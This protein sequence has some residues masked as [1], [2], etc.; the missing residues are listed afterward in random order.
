MTPNPLPSA[1]Q[2]AQKAHLGACFSSGLDSITSRDPSQPLQFCGSVM[3]VGWWE[4]L[5]RTEAVAAGQG[6]PPGFLV[7][8]GPCSCC[9]GGSWLHTAC[10]MPQVLVSWGRT[11]LLQ[12]MCRRAHYCILRSSSC[13]WFSLP[14]MSKLCSFSLIFYLTVCHRVGHKW[15]YLNS[16]LS[17]RWGSG[18]ESTGIN[19]HLQPKD[20]GL[21]LCCPVCV[22]AKMLLQNVLLIEAG[23]LQRMSWMRWL[24]KYVL[25]PL[26]T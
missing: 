21:W 9:L 23:A 8:G 12:E 1:F 26:L 6:S 13:L 24:P 5:C 3:A 16:V 2:R 15:K 22:E 14:R 19:G 7:P 4:V 17:S 11:W 10:G 18:E 25:L 20:F